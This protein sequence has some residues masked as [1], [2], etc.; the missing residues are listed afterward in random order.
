[1]RKFPARVPSLLAAA[2][3][4]FLLTGCGGDQ[5]LESNKQLVLQ[6]QTQIEQMQQQIEALKNNQAT[7]YTPGVSSNNSG[8]DRGVETTATQRGGER[9]A[10]GDFSRALGYYQD[11]VTACPSDD[12]AQL[13]VAR[14]YEALGETQ[15]AIKIYRRVA[16]ENTTTV[17]TSQTQAQNALV[18]LQASQLP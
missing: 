5:Q 10:A 7:G 14:T 8:C 11:A 3:A 12:H 13:N 17:T 18:R 16:G 9:F 15:A 6:Q 2:L 4:T 1:M